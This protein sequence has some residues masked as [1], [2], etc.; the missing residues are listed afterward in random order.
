M[1]QEK[2]TGSHLLTVENRS[3]L[4]AT[5]VLDVDHFD[6]KNIVALTQLGVL[7]VEGNDLHINRLNV[8]EGKLIIEGEIDQVRYTDLKEKSGGVLKSLFR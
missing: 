7:T 3:L 2:Q 1:E 5:G 8:E 4:T 6:E